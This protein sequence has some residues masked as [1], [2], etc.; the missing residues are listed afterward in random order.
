MNDLFAPYDLG[1]LQLSNRFVMAPMTR[2]RAPEDIATEQIALHYTQRGTA[3]LIVSEGTPISREGQGYLFNPGI[4]TEQQVQG[5]KLVTDS[6]HSVGGKI[7]AQ[8]WHVGRV[9]HTSIQRDGQAPVSA[10]SKVAQGAIAF[11]YTDSGEPGFVPTSTPRPLNTEEVGRVVEDFAQAAANAVAAGF[12]GV[13]IHGANGYL[14]EQF[15]NPLVNDRSDRYAADTLE[16]RLRFVF[17]VVDA[18]VRRIGADKV[19]IR[20]SPYGQLFDMPIY[21]QIDETYSAL[22]AGM[23]QRGIAYVHVM[24][25]THFFL[26]SEGAVAQ[27][28]ALR[29]LLAQCKAQLGQTALILAG[30]MTLER[31]QD[32]VDAGLIDLAGFGQPFIANPDLVA[33][34]K[35]G[36]PL[37]APDRDTYYGGGAK[38]YL[39][40]A[41][42][43]PA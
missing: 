24:D 2:S 22:C 31:A 20:I 14:I 40:Y 18:V 35:N 19:G 1:S 30:D 8:L 34:L 6:V 25:Q 12:D 33:R 42:Y 7:F 39:D 3:G 17:E 32:L 16:N 41:P 28:Q 23:G 10:T 13:E 36:W 26:A 4:F 5:W 27:E 21:A 9:S 38:G 15:L 37:T 43:A 11:G 29:E